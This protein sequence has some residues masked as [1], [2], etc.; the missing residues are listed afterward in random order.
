MIVYPQLTATEQLALPALT[1]EPTAM[2]RKFDDSTHQLWHCETVDGPMVL[3]VCNHAAVAESGFWQAINVLFGAD[4]PNNLK[5]ADKTY[6]CLAEKGALVI[7]ELIASNTNRFVL[8]RFLVGAD[9]SPTQVNHEMVLQLAN[10]ISQLHHYQYN[11]WGDLHTPSQASADW[12]SRLQQVLQMLAKKSELLVP[13]S[14]LQEMVNQAGS[15]EETTFVP[16]MLDLRWDQFRLLNHAQ[17]NNNMA[18]IDLDAFV[19]G[20]PSLELILLEYLLSPEQFELFKQ[21]Y[22]THHHWPEYTLQKSC[23]QLLLFLMNVLGETNLERWMSKVS[24]N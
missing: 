10:H 19:I 18:L 12:A 1:A 13:E 2:P 3:K 21:Q 24:V 5:L 22:T 11:R 6:R 14:I 23:Y 9:I 15:I 8:T 7:P 16:I 17:S 4:F 20:P